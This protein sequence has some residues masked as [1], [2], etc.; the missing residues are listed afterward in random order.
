MSTFRYR[1]LEHISW[2]VGNEGADFL[3][4]AA[5]EKIEVDFNVDIPK[6]W[7]KSRLKEVGL[8]NW[9]EKWENSLEARHTFGLM[10]KIDLKRC[11]RIFT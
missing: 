5:T 3:A 6:S 8:Q 2:I 7:I 10:H 1:N 11:M 9:P 4:K